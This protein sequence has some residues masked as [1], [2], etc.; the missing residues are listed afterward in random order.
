MNIDLNIACKQET[1]ARRNFVRLLSKPRFDHS[2]GQGIPRDA[3]Y[4]TLEIKKDEGV[5]SSGTAWISLVS[6]KS[7]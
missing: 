3:P 2:A 7:R 4:M 5:G 1:Y 6:M